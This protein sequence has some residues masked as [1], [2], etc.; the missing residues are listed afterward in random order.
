MCAHESLRSTNL[1]QKMRPQEE[2]KDMNLLLRD[3]EVTIFARER[4]LLKVLV[5]LSLSLSGEAWEESLW[6]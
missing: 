3:L 6:Q 4:E 5:L 2:I 1:E